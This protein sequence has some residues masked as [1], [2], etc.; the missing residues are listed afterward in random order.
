MT[1]VE[2]KSSPAIVVPMD[3]SSI[4]METASTFEALAKVVTVV[5]ITM[6]KTDAERE[7][8]ISSPLDLFDI[9]QPI[10]ALIP[11]KIK[12]THP[13]TVLW[14]LLATI[15]RTAIIQESAPMVHLAPVNPDT[16]PRLTMLLVALPSLQRLSP[17][18]S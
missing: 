8:H 1:Q 6:M 16:G 9:T 18:Y 15:I 13:I 17:L 3:E 7:L 12:P 2:I 5:S 14:V 10:I 4:M 11:Q